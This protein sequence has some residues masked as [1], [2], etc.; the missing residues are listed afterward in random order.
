V[1]RDILVHVDGTEAGRRRVAYALDLAAQHQ[2]RLTGLHVTSPVDVPPQFRPSL[3]ETVAA[4]LEPRSEQ[5]AEGAET[6][7]RAVAARRAAA[8]RGVETVWCGTEGGMAREIC[9]RASCSDLVILGQY[10]HEGTPERHPLTLAES[11]AQAC[12]RPVLVVPAAVGAAALRRALIAWDGGREVVRALHDALP[13]LRQA[14]TMVEIVAIDESQAVAGLQPLLDHLHRHRIEREEE[15]HLR[16]NG[17][18][19]EMLL[20]RLARGRYDLL[21]MGGSGHSGWFEFLFGGTTPVTLA[22]ASAPVLL[23]A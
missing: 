22:N 15:V 14:R 18:T 10:E 20:E 12:G 9:T 23:A 1:I 17:S 21:V 3:V 2:A 7:F 19:A 8:G 11:V 6:L 4:A 13:L 5:A 16:P